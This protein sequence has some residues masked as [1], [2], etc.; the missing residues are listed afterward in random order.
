MDYRVFSSS[1][2]RLH[3]Y[4]GIMEILK[5]MVCVIIYD[6]TPRTF[7]TEGRPGLINDK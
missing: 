6:L 4:L 2:L 3:F 5:E 7:V 1:F